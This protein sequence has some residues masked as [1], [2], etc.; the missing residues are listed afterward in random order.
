M[1]ETMPELDVAATRRDLLNLYPPLI[2]E[3]ALYEIEFFV[4]WGILPADAMVIEAIE[5]VNGTFI[6]IH[7]DPGTAQ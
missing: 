5:V 4:A 1:N 3:Q 6:F 7:R 2:A